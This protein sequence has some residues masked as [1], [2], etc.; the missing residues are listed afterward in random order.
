MGRKSR[1]SSLEVR[2]EDGD[3]NAADG[4]TCPFLLPIHLVC[5]GSD[6]AHPDQPS[7]AHRKREEELVVGGAGRGDGPKTSRAIEN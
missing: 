3:L 1:P 6:A 2:R 5:V 7:G 4:L